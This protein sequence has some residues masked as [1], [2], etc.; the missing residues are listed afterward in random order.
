MELFLVRLSKSNAFKI[1]SHEGRETR[2]CQ[3]HNEVDR[4]VKTV[5]LALSLRHE[6]LRK[7]KLVGNM[8]SETC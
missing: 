1:K 2:L 4:T 8:H 5:S 3:V 6:R 7:S